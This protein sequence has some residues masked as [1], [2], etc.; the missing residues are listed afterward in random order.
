[1]GAQ[2]VAIV[3]L[4]CA[5]LAG[6]CRQILG[7]GSVTFTSGVGGAGGFGGDGGHG[8]D[9]GGGST[10][11]TSSGACTMTLCGSSCVDTD[12]DDDNC[13]ACGRGC[14]SQ[15]V[16]ALLCA[17]GVCAS[18]CNAGWGNCSLPAAPAGDDGCETNTANDNNNCGTCGNACVNNFNCSNGRCGCSGEDALCTSTAAGTCDSNNLC[19]CNGNTCSPGQRCDSSGCGD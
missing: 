11:T 9:G 5:A 17:D 3:A 8:G 10:S 18:L 19:V 2:R 15:N 6:S 16:H 13:G 14:S 12:A 7:V 4:S 1:M